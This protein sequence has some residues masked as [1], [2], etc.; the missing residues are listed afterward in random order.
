MATHVATRVEVSKYRECTD[1]S[2]KDSAQCQQLLGNLSSNIA[3]IATRDCKDAATTFFQCFNHKF[4]LNEC[5]PEATTKF[6]QCQE[7]TVKTLL[8]S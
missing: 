4:N 7:N 5:G 1:K 6:V 2:G 3:S 8:K